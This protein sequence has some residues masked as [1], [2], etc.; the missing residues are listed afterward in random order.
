MIDEQTAFTEFEL[1]YRREFR[2][3]YEYLLCFYDLH[4]SEQSYFWNA[5]KVTKDTSSELEAFV[6]LVS[7]LSS[8]EKVLTGSA[9]LVQRSKDQA[10][11]FADAINESAA[12]EEFSMYP[13]FNTSVA[14]EAGLEGARVQSR[15]TLGDA[16]GPEEPLFDNG[17]VASPDG[18]HWSQVAS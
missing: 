15:A 12:A 10:K 13:I 17:L 18:M 11:E 3:F 7:G 8:N 16:A 9:A 1:R 14:R 5:K 4:V 2:V 6:N